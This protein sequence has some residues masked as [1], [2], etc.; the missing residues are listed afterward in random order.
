MKSLMNNTV[1]QEKLKRIRSVIAPYKDKV[2][3]A[4]SDMQE[5]FGGERS[6]IGVDVG[7]SSVK[8]VQMADVNGELTLIKSALVNIGGVPGNDEEV[9]ASLKTALVGFETKGAKV[10][11]VVNCPQTCTRKIV[12]PNMP[13]KELT[14]AIKWEA[15]NAIPFSIDE[16]LMGFDILGEVVENGVKKMIVAVAATPKETVDRLL[17]LF[18]KANIEIS[19]MIPMSVSLQNLIAASQEKKG[20]NIA[21]V[22]IGASITE[23]NIYQKGRLAFSRKLP[24]AGGDITRAMTSTLMSSEGKVELTF[25]EA[26]KIK[27]EKG[28]PVGEDTES[29][30][31]KIL[32]SQILSLVRPCV[33]QLANEIERSFDFFREESHGGKVDKIVLFGGGA[34]LKGLTK[35][36]FDELE[37][38]IVIGNSFEDVKVSSATDK[39]DDGEA[40]RFDLAVGAV[41]SQS[42]KINL[43]PIELKEK[44]KRFVEHVS[45]QAVAVGIATTMLLSYIGLNIKLG[46]Q[47]KK[48][49]ALVLEQKTLGPQVEAMRQM[50]VAD[51]IL[52]VRPHWEDVLRE[53]SNVMQPKMY[54][55]E[56]SMD[57]DKVNFAG[58]INQGDQGAQAILSNFMITLEDG[59]FKDV[60]LVTSRRETEGKLTFEFEIT[61]EVE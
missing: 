47:H 20:M 43:L 48:L 2:S 8:V 32:P 52:N 9:L 17:S 26:E 11:A 24:I 6:V 49:D 40:S 5:K 15:K 28:I 38:E 46:A 59:I 44:T 34:E 25:E 37:I 31:G 36:L 3:G 33:E 50:L 16:A 23:L 10:I 21:I 42:V 58:V 54:L 35:S 51:Q 1:I 55:T 29:I 57:N 22:D 18:S 39:K 41:L 12:T 7:A 53:I 13:K 19:T 30:D 56:L 27:K 4:L 14:E 60:S 61:A 45:L